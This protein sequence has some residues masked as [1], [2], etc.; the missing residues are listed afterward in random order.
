MV[1]IR[2]V[3]GQFSLDAKISIVDMSLAFFSFSNE[4]TFDTP[5]PFI[6]TDILNP[7]FRNFKK[8]HG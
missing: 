3:I 7:D 6:S 2:S 4:I 8:N 1:Y 5:F